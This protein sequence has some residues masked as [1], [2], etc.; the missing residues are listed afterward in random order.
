MQYH[1]LA[2]QVASEKSNDTINLTN[3]QN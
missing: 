3:Y 2:S 1:H